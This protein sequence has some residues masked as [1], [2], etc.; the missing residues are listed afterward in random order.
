MAFKTRGNTWEI[1][2]VCSARSKKG[3]I[4]PHPAL[5]IWDARPDFEYLYVSDL[6]K[7]PEM[8]KGYFRSLNLP[9]TPILK[10]G[11]V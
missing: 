8:T 2:V 7:Q 11:P 3:V 5:L 9:N 1:L 6:V 4:E 10:E